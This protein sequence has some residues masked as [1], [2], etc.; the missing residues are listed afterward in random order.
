MCEIFKSISL[1]LLLSSVFYVLFKSISIGFLS[2][3]QI[4]TASYLSLSLL[5]DVKSCWNSINILASK[6]VKSTNS[7]QKRRESFQT[8]SQLLHE[9]GLFRVQHFWFFSLFLYSQLLARILESKQRQVTIHRQNISISTTKLSFYVSS[10][11]NS[12]TFPLTSNT[13]LP[14]VCCSQ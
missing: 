12:F 8:S 14:F 7:I 10:N 4:P 3:S 2:H 11:I 5:L 9:M 1:L 6:H 13:T